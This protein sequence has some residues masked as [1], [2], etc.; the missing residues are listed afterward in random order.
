MPETAALQP[1]TKLA[2]PIKITRTDD[3]A[4]V[5]L[6]LL[7]SQLAP[8]ANNQPDPNKTLR[9]ERAVELAAKMN[10]GELTL[11]VPAELTNDA[12]DVAVQ[13]EFLS[14][15]KQK[16]LA[17]SFTPV[18][19]LAVQL[20]VELQL[21][22]EPKFDVMLDPAKGATQKIE[23]TIKRR[24]GITGDVVI[25]LKGLPAGVTADSPTI[26]AEE[27][28]FTLTITLPANQVAGE[29]DGLKVTAAIAPDPKQ[30]NVRVKSREVELKLNVIRPAT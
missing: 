5:R 15:D 17:T 3:K 7:T 26:K 20:P 22:A 4:A 27:S 10:D 1:T 11:L 25:A 24:E 28:A 12:Y 16:V 30:A 9:V 29:I 14:A 21:A 19:R 18:R 13:A 8:S 6:S 23:G 2:L